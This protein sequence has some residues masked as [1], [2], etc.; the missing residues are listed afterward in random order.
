M[1][2][3]EELLAKQEKINSALL[4]LMPGEEVPQRK[5]FEAM[6]YSLTCG[7]KRIR[8]VLTLA[9]C[10]A[11]SGDTDMAIPFACA[12]EMIHTYSLIHDDLPAMDNDDFRR[13][14]PTNHKVF[15]EAMAI[16]A[17]DALLNYAFE[18]AS[19]ADAPD[20]VKVKAM[21]VLGKVSGIY[22]M[23]GGQVLDMEGEK[24]KLTGEELATMHAMKTGALIRGAAS[25]GCV[26]AGKDALLY[27]KFADN[28]GKAF[29]IKDDILDETSTTEEL[30][31]NVGS[32]RKNDKSTYITLYG[33]EK[34]QKMLEDTTNAAISAL[35][36]TGGDNRFLKEL[37]M[38]LLNRKS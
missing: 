38:Y 30:G 2:F 26:A 9:V 32:D 23:I 1:N 10:E 19:G 25:L 18:V 33:M 35:D 29:Q 22:G 34:T 20:S 36:E 11:L 16:L 27:D 28:L 4:S 31:K 6:A 17:G 15:G 24:R 7:G 14:R 3:K 13:G 12:L 21:K 37:A 8:P 5:I